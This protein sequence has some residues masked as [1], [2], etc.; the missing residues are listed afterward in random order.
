M[1]DY[2]A[3]NGL[4][5]PE[6]DDIINFN[7]AF[8]GYAQAIDSRLHPRYST[9]TDRDAAIT[10]AAGRTPGMQASTGN[11]PQMFFDNNVWD[12]WGAWTYVRKGT[13]EA[14]AATG[15]I[16][17][18]SALLFG[19]FPNSMYEVEAVLM[20]FATGTA[21]L[22]GFTFNFLY[23]GV[24][25]IDRTVMGPAP[26]STNYENY[27]MSSRLWPAATDTTVG[28]PGTASES[29][30]VEARAIFSTVA[31]TTFNVFWGASTALGG[32]FMTMHSASYIRWRRLQP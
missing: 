23:G 9:T 30:I 27:A 26:G 28:H 7:E 16:A 13:N 4:P 8:G 18:D 2:S 14:K 3:I 20:P 22:T 1:T 25:N 24:K 21:G 17:A 5:L 32:A 10:P 11:T 15:A 31:S 6:D 19:C 12:D 29:I